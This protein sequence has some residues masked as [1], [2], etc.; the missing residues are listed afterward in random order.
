[1]Q[2]AKFPPIFKG[3]SFLPW[4]L[5][6]FG[7]TNIHVF[8]TIK[9]SRYARYVWIKF[10]WQVL[11]LAWIVQMSTK[12]QKIGRKKGSVLLWQFSQNFFYLF[13]KRDGFVVDILI[14][15]SV[16]FLSRV[17]FMQQPPKFGKCENMF[18]YSAHGFIILLRQS[19]T[20]SD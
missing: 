1:M 11:K 15:Q 8:L 19:Q 20:R 10:P 6:K 18:T 9:L 2:I 16:K 12:T 4:R 3:S 17:R 13:L 7:E 5:P 14:N